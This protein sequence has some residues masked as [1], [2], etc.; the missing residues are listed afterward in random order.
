MYIKWKLLIIRRCITDRSETYCCKKNEENRQSLRSKRSRLKRL[1][2]FFFSPRFCDFVS[3]RLPRSR[4]K[5][6]RFAENVSYRDAFTD[7]PE[8]SSRVGKIAGCRPQRRLS[9]RVRRRA[10]KTDDRSDLDLWTAR[11]ARFA[12][13]VPSI[14]PGLRLTSGAAPA[15]ATPRNSRCIVH[16][17]SLNPDAARRII[18]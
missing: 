8:V 12:R 9:C 4:A 6:E 3:R 18:Y 7:A 13:G 16:R 2:F 10:V 17:R 1:T 11:R 14:N 15:P 5:S